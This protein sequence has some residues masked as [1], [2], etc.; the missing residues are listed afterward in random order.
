M[1]R[2]EGHASPGGFGPL[3]GP[4]DGDQ[5]E[6]VNLFSQTMGQRSGER[7]L[8]RNNTLIKMSSSTE[9]IAELHTA[10]Y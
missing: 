9:S 8:H 3:R 4:V 7:E 5:M 2:A 10:G 6:H 1:L